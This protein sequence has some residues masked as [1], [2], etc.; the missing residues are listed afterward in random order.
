MYTLRTIL[1]LLL[2]TPAL[3]CLSQVTAKYFTLE[4]KP[5]G[6]GDAKYTRQGV[7]D[8]DKWHVFE[9]RQYFKTPSSE[10]W[11][12]DSNFTIPHGNYIEYSDYTVKKISK[13]GQYTNGKKNRSLD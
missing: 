5:T 12:L 11:Y 9:F 3:S 4:Y 7:P 1:L 10:A 13:R 2:L 8:G 6:S